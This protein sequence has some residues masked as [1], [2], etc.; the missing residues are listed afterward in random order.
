MQNSDPGFNKDDLLVMEMR[1][2]TFKKSL[3][4]FQTGIAQES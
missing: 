3:E 2:T 4:P 1:D